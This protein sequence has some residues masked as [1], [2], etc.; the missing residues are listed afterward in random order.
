MWVI[1]LSLAAVG[2]G[3]AWAKLAA[4][5]AGE[6]TT[7]FAV[8]ALLGG[9]AA[10]GLALAA[11]EAAARLGVDVS[12]ERIARGDAAAFLFAAAVG[13]VEEGAKLTGLLLVVERG[14]RTR[15]ALA[16]AVGVA[17]GFSA[18]E[19]LVVLGGERS[20]LAFTRAALGPVAHALLAV[21]F[22]LAVAP[23]LRSKRP[24][25]GLA[26]PLVASAALHGA[27]DLSIA[28]PGVGHVGYALALAA[29]AFMLFARTRA[30]RRRALPGAVPSWK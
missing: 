16:A 21:P 29:P 26:I 25:V 2:S 6:R 13:L 27:G 22:A 12:W 10:F 18:L 28:L 24:A 11:Y 1:A 20:G 4:C 3:A 23:A 8:H 19:T 17:A 30:R 15:A 7:A 14:V 5:R 9:A